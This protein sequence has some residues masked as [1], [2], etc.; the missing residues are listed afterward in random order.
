[1]LLCCA[2]CHTRG[3]H[4]VGRGA[5][6]KVPSPG[7]GDSHGRTLILAHSAKMGCTC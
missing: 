4:G 2:S 7:L 5:R 6:D 1:M 3:Q